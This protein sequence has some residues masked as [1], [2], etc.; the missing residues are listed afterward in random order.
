MLRF[1]SKNIG[2]ALFQIVLVATFV[3]LLLRFIP[4]DP[5]QLVLGSETATDPAAVEAMRATLGLDKPLMTQYITWVFDIIH[6]DF[7]QSLFNNME[8]SSYLSERLPRTLELAI[9]AIII[10]SLIGIPLGIIAS[11]KR[12]SFIDVIVSSISAIG[13]SFP[14]YVS[15]TVIILVVSLQLHLLPASGYTNFSENPVLHIQRLILPAITI[16][17]PFAATVARM[18]RSSMLEVLNKEFVQTLRAKGLSEKLVIYKHV[19]RNAI[20]TVITVIGLELGSLIGGTVLIEFLFNWPG[21]STLLVESIN[22]RNYPVIQGA[23]IVIA[24]SFI[25]INRSIEIIYGLIDPRTR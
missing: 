2:V 4:G 13:M 22:N 10:G 7:G 21:L 19:L 9:V 5:A 15:G 18:T 1:I 25:L 14:V 23:V 8:V 3:F 24:A 16:A 11:V 17:L 12:G 6:L 20:M